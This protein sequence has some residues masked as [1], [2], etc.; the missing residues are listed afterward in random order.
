MGKKVEVDKDLQKFLLQAKQKKP[1]YFVFV[2]KGQ[3]G[4]LIVSKKKIKP[5]DIA[6]AKKEVGG[7][8]VYAGVCCGVGGA[9]VVFELTDKE[10]SGGSRVLKR[11]I[12]ENAGLKLKPEFRVVPTLSVVNEDEPDEDI[13]L[14][15]LMEDEQETDEDDSEGELNES[16]TSVPDAPQLEQP[17][18]VAREWKWRFEALQPDLTTVLRDKLGDFEKVRNIF[19]LAQRQKE[20]DL[21]K[22]LASLKVC[23]ELVKRA[24]AS[25]S[26]GETD[27]DEGE[28]S[29]TAEARAQHYRDWM[30]GLKPTLAQI[31]KEGH[32]TFS[33]IAQKISAVQRAVEAGDWQ[34]A[35]S[36]F[37]EADRLVTAALGEIQS[38]QAADV[39]PKG[40]AEYTKARLGWEAACKKAKSDLESLE[41]AILNRCKDEED[42]Q[43]IAVCAVN[44]YSVFNKLDGKLA[45]A[46]DAAANAATPEE[47]KKHHATALSV[48]DRFESTIKE[49]ELIQNVDNNPFKPVAVRKTL[50]GV[51][52]ILRKQLSS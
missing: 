49:D 8:K 15:A 52:S 16:P 32:P 25:Q 44:L 42:F 38:K 17:D 50:D 40:T 6:S 1:R 26:S 12:A 43:E 46:L 13:D 51:L 11:L 28:Q 29:D 33:E 10:P 2:P 24:L 39:I 31:K 41:A 19:E 14:A 36:N 45:Q 23:A 34:S 21:A 18:P 47:R 35:E 48:L 7:S 9:N 27:E 4:K 30:N 22:A 37:T 20:T 3:E 5:G